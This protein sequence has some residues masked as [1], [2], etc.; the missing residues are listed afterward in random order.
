MTIQI[1]QR[2]KNAF[3]KFIDDLISQF[4]DDNNLMLARTFFIDQ[5]PVQTIIEQFI[6]HVHP[7]KERIKKRD[8]EF[9]LKEESLFSSHVENSRVINFK[10]LWTEVDEEVQGII[11]DWVELLVKI[12]EEYRVVIDKT[13]RE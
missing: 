11:W 8:D 1:L 6:V 5:I 4:P 13:K 9:F 3:V 2:F 12:S 7:W 10:K